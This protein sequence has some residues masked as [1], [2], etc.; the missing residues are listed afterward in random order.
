MLLSRPS[1]LTQTQLWVWPSFKDSSNNVIADLTPS[2]QSTSLVAPSPSLPLI[3]THTLWALLL[4][5]TTLCW[6]CIERLCLGWTHGDVVKAAAG[7]VLDVEVGEVEQHAV[8]RFDG[9]LPDAVGPVRVGV[10]VVE[11][12][13]YSR[14]R[15]VPTATA[16]VVRTNDMF[17]SLPEQEARLSPTTTHEAN[18][19]NV[20]FCFSV[21][22][23]PT[24][25]FITYYLVMNHVQIGYVLVGITIF[26]PTLNGLHKQSFINRTFCLI[27]FENPLYCVCLFDSVYCVYVRH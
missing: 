20:S 3:I 15:C 23:D 16:Y 27:M 14:P 7:R 21:W 8:S 24:I 5:D 4:P 12:M 2:K 26:L 17:S 13:D 25:A 9:D 18:S 22:R 11:R 1:G 10:W 6:S 19:A